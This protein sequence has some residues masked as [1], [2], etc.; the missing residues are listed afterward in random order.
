MQSAKFV[1]ATQ[2]PGG[3]RPHQRGSPPPQR[4]TCACSCATCCSSTST[5]GGAPPEL[6]AVE[7]ISSKRCASTRTSVLA[8]VASGSA[9]DTASSWR[10][11]ADSSC[12]RS[13]DTLPTCESEQVVGGCGAGGGGPGSTEGKG[14][15]L[16]TVCEGGGQRARR[17]SGCGQDSCAPDDGDVAVTA[18]RLVECRCCAMNDNTTGVAGPER[19]RPTCAG[20]R[21]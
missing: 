7:R 2:R 20:Q 18:R 21:G 13:L 8:D 5:P 6:V 17:G 3:T 11:S 15:T 12:A 16:L 10:R 9:G 19:Y 4:R 1:L 14:E